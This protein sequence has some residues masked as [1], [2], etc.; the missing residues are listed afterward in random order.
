MK[1]SQIRQLRKTIPFE[2]DIKTNKDQIAAFGRLFCKEM[3]TIQSWESGY[4]NPS[5]SSLRDLRI[6]W[7]LKFDGKPPSLPE[8]GV[9][10]SK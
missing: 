2:G 10:E 5:K 7:W 6:M 8:G 1:P 3:R 9:D 4:R